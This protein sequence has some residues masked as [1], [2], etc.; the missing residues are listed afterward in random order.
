MIGRT[1]IR[2][3]GVPVYEVLL[4]RHPLINQQSKAQMKYKDK[5]SEVCLQNQEQ[6]PLP[7]VG[8]LCEGWKVTRLTHTY[9][10]ILLV[11]A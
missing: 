8:D 11:P 6:S 3:L 1:S 9:I 4:Y 7:I 10:H 2:L 5:S